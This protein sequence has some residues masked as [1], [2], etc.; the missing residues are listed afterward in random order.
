[1]DTRLKEIEA[2]IAKLCNEFNS[3]AVEL[4]E[5]FEASAADNDEDYDD[6]DVRYDFPRIAYIT[7]SAG[8]DY[9]YFH[10][11]IHDDTGWFPSSIC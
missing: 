7:S 11:R 2:K 3:L 1:M 5:E 8:E 10:G 4:T 6:S 9:D